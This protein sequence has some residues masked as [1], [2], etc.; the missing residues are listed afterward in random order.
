MRRHTCR[1]IFAVGIT[2]TTTAALLAAPAAVDAAAG[3]AVAIAASGSNGVGSIAAPGLPCSQGGN[4]DNRQYQLQ[5]ALAPGAFSGLASSLVAT[6]DVFTDNALAPVSGGS[7]SYL[8]TANSHASLENDRGTVQL[9]LTASGPANAVGTC[10]QGRLSFDG[11]TVSGSGTW[12]VG[13]STGAYRNAA[14]SGTFNLT[15]SLLPGATNPWSLQ[16][17][18]T[19]TIGEPTLAMGSA[20]PFWGSLGL[21]YFTRIV[22]V[23][24]TVKNTGAGDAFATALTGVTSPTPGVTPLGPTALP[25]GDIPAGKSV[26][27]TERYQ[28]GK[29]LGQPCIAV[30]LNCTFKTVLSIDMPDA[31]DVH[32]VQTAT[33][34]VTAPPLPPPL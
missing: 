29:G 12:T 24:Y 23:T 33:A 9:L 31:F 26:S 28:L 20:T 7:N 5:S 8:L 27:F 13:P 10:P 17:N 32:G 14:G 25:L 4:G 30:V 21:D 18:G 3:H 1:T 34:T 6:V 16:L 2:L 22:S 19:V 11:T 15:A